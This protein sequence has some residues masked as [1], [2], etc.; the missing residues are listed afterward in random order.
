MS[1]IDQKLNSRSI[2]LFLELVDAY[3]E[4]KEAVGSR[5]L[6]KRSQFDISSATIRN[7][8][9]DLEDLGLLYA[10]HT[11]AGRIPTEAGLRFF[12]NSI[13]E[14]SDI[15]TFDNEFKLLY[16]NGNNTGNILENITSVLSGLSKCAGIVSS[17][18][19]DPIIKK[20]DFVL[21]SD[22]NLLTIIV[23]E[24]GHVENRMS[25]FKTR[26]DQDKLQILSNYM[27]SKLTGHTLSQGLYLIKKEIEDHKHNLDKLS[28]E[29][30]KQGIE[31]WRDENKSDSM[32]LKG[33]ANLLDNID[34]IEELNDIKD[35]FET[36][37]TKTTMLQLLNSASKADGVQV[38]IG[39]ENPYF[40]ISGCSLVLSPYKSNDG[41]IIGSVGVIGPTHMEYRKII[42]LVNYTSKVISKFLNK[43]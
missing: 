13:L 37:D 40:Q 22:D 36:M 10:P 18:K 14:C 21:L 7:I 32:I 23:S 41:K 25:K 15:E 26:I 12:I 6:S 17:P 8:M 30:L 20:I 1:D 27:S 5:L 29:L 39:S 2:E 11:S 42:P 38:F 33:Y 19:A 43:K 34:E 28:E 4:T 24:N 3:I 9:A 31:V 16:E 35:L